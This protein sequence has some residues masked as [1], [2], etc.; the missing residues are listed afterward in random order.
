MAT[1]DHVPELPAHRLAALVRSR[2][3]N[4]S[5]VVEAHLRRIEQLNGQLGAFVSVRT[6]AVREEAASLAARHDLA[7]LTLAGVLVAIKDNVD[8]AGEVTCCGSRAVHGP[9][10]D[11]DDELVS[12]LRAAGALIVGKTSMPELAIWPFTETD[13]GRPARNPWD[14]SRTPGGSTGG[15][16][17]AVTT[18]MAAL[19]L[20]SDGGGSLRIPAACCGIVGLKPTPGLVPLPGGGRDHWYGLSAFGPLARSVSDAALMLDVLAGRA[21]SPTTPSRDRLRISVS[22]R[23]PAT[24]ARTSGEVLD[25][26]ESVRSALAA[27]GHDVR[28]EHPPYSATP[29]PFA[30]RWLPGIAQD[31][32]G[33]D[34]RE[35]E[36]RTR[37]LA[38]AGRWL[39]RRGLAR[40]VRH[41]RTGARL[42]SW[43][44]DR[45]V[46]VA[47][48]LAGP[49]A[50]V[51]AWDGRG[52]IRTMLGVSQ[53]MGYTPPWNLAA[54]P[55]M[56]V[57]VGVSRDGL[58]IAVQ[59]VAAPGREAQLI[60]AGMQLEGIFPLR[61]WSPPGE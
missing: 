22:T 48:V 20:G 51:G 10:A 11:R 2:E 56:T 17:V 55:A 30:A 57:P 4:P 50:A 23:H 18:G 58:P 37:G 54:V 28:R 46:L 7:G 33:L 31:A 9:A 13:G 25:A 60:A 38:R 47:P 14:P 5:E 1:A 49:P 19:A 8:V 59:L 45:D 32:E 52:W 6:D 27:V 3:L 42:R 29:L 16:A 41:S 61:A 39:Q 35:L 24:G 53:W 21:P 12:R 15:G 44:G 40:H 43:L 26:V 36:S 34:L